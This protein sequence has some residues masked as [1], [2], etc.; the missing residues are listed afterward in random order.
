MA[1]KPA[2]QPISREELNALCPFDTRA[3]AVQACLQQAFTDPIGRLRF[4]GRYTSWN[5]F[6]GSGVA[7]LAGKIGRARR[8]FLD[9]DQP[10]QALADRSVFIASYF[11]D[12]A[13][14][15]FDDRDTVHR[16]THR[17]L[18]QSTLSGIISAAAADQPE[19]AHAA[20]LNPLLAEPDWLQALNR[21]VAEGYGAHSEDSAEAIFFSIGYHLGS[22]ILAD[23]EFSLI[24][25]VLRHECPQLVDYLREHQVNIAGQNHRAYQWIAI[26]SGHG[27]AVEADHFRWAVRGADLAFKH[28]PAEQHAHLR[29]Q[30]HQGFRRFAD[31]HWLFFSQVNASSDSA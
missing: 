31:D 22:E 25:E 28:L 7:S 27:S 24:D 10:V 15:E 26:H 18:A 16:D 20:T 23:R 8:L 30:L 1:A 29:E 14:D 2:H 13:R 4:I 6:F 21:Q 17:C 9:P 3:A 19:L 11:F 5:G 12:A